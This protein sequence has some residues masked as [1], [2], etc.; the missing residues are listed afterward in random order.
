MQICFRSMLL[1]ICLT[2]SIACISA[3]VDIDNDI[4]AYVLIEA[5]T[6]TV[7]D[8]KNENKRIN[9]GYLTKLMSILV[10]AK[11]IEN[12]ELSVHDELTASES[13]SGTKGS[14]IWLQSGDKISVDELLKA[15]IIGNA[16]D[17][18]T[19]LAEAVSGDVDTFV[20][21]MNAEAFDIGLR[22]SFFVSP[23][24]YADER[25]YTS[26]HDIAIICS[27][28]SKYDFLQQYFKIWRDFI[29]NEQV[30]L[31]S[32]NTLTRNYE[33]HIGFKACHSSDDNYF[34]AEGGRSSGGNTFISVVLGAENADIS[35]KKGKE[36]LKKAFSKYRIVSTEFPEEMLMPLKVKNGVASAVEIGIREQGKAAV[37][38]GD[39]SIRSK[40]V[41]PEYI[42][43]PVYEGQPVGVAAFFN[44]D[45][46]VFETD[47]I[48]KSAVHK[49][50]W[51]Y[52]LKQTL[53]KMIEK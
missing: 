2:A 44:G 53:L 36:L 33:P 18:M 11:H 4:T 27:K 47:I 21:D 34:L 41:I 6:G 42:N 25:E 14:V 24:G 19:V 12:G 50:S 13:V 16:N 51:S 1:F 23:Y 52:V 40:V 17:A 38:K 7:L 20:M 39:T 49:L 43:A 28:L 15:V 5:D 9:A 8:A 48:T 37:K 26:A 22:D 31:V 3:D 45:T 29:R 32:E 35:F 30:E 10:V 46:I